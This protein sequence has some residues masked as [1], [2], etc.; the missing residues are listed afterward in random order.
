MSE[1][2]TTQPPSVRVLPHELPAWMRDAGLTNW[3]REPLRDDHVDCSI[4]SSS[5]TPV[6]TQAAQ[7]GAMIWVAW[8]QTTCQRP[9]RSR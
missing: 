7:S 2:I 9:S 1:A 3:I 5:Q 4:P 6:R 8:D